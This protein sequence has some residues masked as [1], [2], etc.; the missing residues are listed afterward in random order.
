MAA[1]YT[2]AQVREL[3]EKSIPSNVD[4]V[5]AINQ[6]GDRAYALGRWADTREEVLISASSIFQDA[7]SNGKHENDWMLYLDADLYD[8]A[9]AFDVNN[10]PRRVRPITELY[11]FPQTGYQ[12]FI[13]MGLSEESGGWK[14]K[15]KLPRGVTSSDYITA[16]VKKRW[17]LIYDDA[18]EVP[19]R[20]L[21]AIKAGIDAVSY[22]NNHDVNEAAAKWVE[23]ETLLFRDDKQFQG[24]K[25]ARIKMNGR[26]HRKPTSFM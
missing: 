13:D 20:P 8:G 22:E 24:P 19:I 25:K 10:I 6:C 5:D 18:A 26:Y 4:L 16:L 14:R 9:I 7:T 15:Y 23:F 1:F 12:D 3:L 2:V 17:V 11:R 21:A